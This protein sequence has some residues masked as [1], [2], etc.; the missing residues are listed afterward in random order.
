MRK[1]QLRL[2]GVCTSAE[3]RLV[4]KKLEMILVRIPGT[5]PNRGAEEKKGGPKSNRHILRVQSPACIPV[6]LPTLA[7]RA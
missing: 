4:S 1:G 3:M 5:G 2:S 6:R 7:P